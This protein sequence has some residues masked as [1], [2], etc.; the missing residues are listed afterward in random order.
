M[1]AFHRL[2]VPT[3]F[4][5]LPAGY[6]Y[7]N[8]ALVG[9]PANADTAKVGGPNAGTYFIAFGEDATSADGNRPALALATNTD[10]LDNQ[11]RQS[12]AVPAATIA[13]NTG[14]SPLASLTLTGPGIFMGTSNG[15]TL[16]GSSGFLLL[17]LFQ[18]VDYGD[19]PIQTGGGGIYVTAATDLGGSPVTVGGGFSSGNV[20]LVFNVSIPA[21]QEYRIYYAMQSSMAVFPSDCLTNTY[22]RDINALAAGFQNLFKAVHGNSEAWNATFDS[23]VWDLTARGLD[24]AYRRSQTG[25]AGTLGV[26]GSGAVISRDGPAPGVKSAS[27]TGRTYVDTYQQL[28]GVFEKETAPS[29]STG[30]VPS[31]GYVMERGTWNLKGDGQAYIPPAYPFADLVANW[32]T[33]PVTGSPI[34]GHGYATKIPAGVAATISTTSTAG[35]FSVQVTTGSCWFWLY[36]SGGAT[37]ETTLSLGRDMLRCVIPGIGTVSLV[38]TS[39]VTSDTTGTTVHCSTLDGGTLNTLPAGPTTIAITLVQ[40]RMQLGG[41]ASAIN[42]ALGSIS[43]GAE[44]WTDDMFFCAPVCAPVTMDVTDTTGNWVQYFTKINAYF[45]A[46]F[47]WTAASNTSRATP[48][49]A[50][51]WGS[52]QRNVQDANFG[53]WLNSGQLL[54]DGSVNATTV[55]TPYYGSVP[56]R[57]L[58]NSGLVASTTLDFTTEATDSVLVAKPAAQTCELR[59]F[60]GGVA[61]TVYLHLPLNAKIGDKFKVIISEVTQ[62]AQFPSSNITVAGSRSGTVGGVSYEISTL[63]ANSVVGSTQGITG[64]TDIWEIECIYA[65]IISGTY[66]T[67]YLVTAHCYGTGI[68]GTYIGTA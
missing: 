52:L 56:M 6:D 27:P 36:A 16:A 63:L 39:L 40:P 28:W 45:G 46:H 33:V 1:A 53:Q 9:T 62:T 19:Q 25:V 51:S 22:S 5:G 55:M 8:N 50:L 67:T 64:A 26:T 21:G 7:I 48:G 44:A 60:S 32:S 42:E 41:G 31:S 34:S 54:A 15:V 68:S 58:V 43:V 23:T 18:V 37:Q 65:G 14:G 29:R 20:S 10:Y 17:D 2:T 13:A 3:Y 59:C 35:V 49:S 30:L 24:G 38:I 61:Q 12:I 11:M 47:D 66:Q 57:Y 4:G